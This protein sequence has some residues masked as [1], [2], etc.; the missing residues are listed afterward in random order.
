MEHT[1]V[2]DGNMI[3]VTAKLVIK[4]MVQIMK[5]YKVG[6]RIMSDPFKLGDTPMVIAVYPNGWNIKSIGYVSLFLINQGDA[7]I[8]L[9]GEVSTDLA[10]MEF[11]Y[12]MSIPPGALGV[13]TLLTHAQ[14]TEA[15]KDKDFVVTAKLELPGEPVR[16]VGSHSSNAPKKKF[17]VLENVYKK[18]QRTDFTLAPEL[19]S[20]TTITLFYCPKFKVLKGRA[21]KRQGKVGNFP[22]WATLFPQ[23]GN[24][25]P[26]FWQSA[27][28]RL[29]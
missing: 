22:K 28:Y 2:I 11:D 19:L 25:C 13:S 12:T 9:K 20:V 21:Q 16:V 6:Q 17:S 1:T 14:C 4:N 18:M 27:S 3:H 24:C 15:Y 8:S 23:Y 29:G 5:G 10:E 7:D 26:I